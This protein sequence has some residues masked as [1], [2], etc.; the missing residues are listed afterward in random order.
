MGRREIIW[1]KPLKADGV[2]QGSML[3]EWPNWDH[4]RLLESSLQLC[5]EASGIIQLRSNP[6]VPA[7]LCAPPPP[8][9]RS[10]V[11]ALTSRTSG[12]DCIWR[13]HVETGLWTGDEGQMRLLGWALFRSD[14]CP[15]ERECGHGGRVHEHRR[16]P[17][18]THQEDSWPSASQGEAE[19]ESKS[20][21]TLMLT[22]GLQHCEK[23]DVWCS[24]HRVCGILS[25]QL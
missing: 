25:W 15:C 21:D 7:E 11:E 10:Y 20:A 14:C 19:E 2:A 1:A 13:L 16:D 3:R 17:M 12:C 8:P 4:N 9:H 18:K 24:S 22:S 5:Y 23:R 6:P